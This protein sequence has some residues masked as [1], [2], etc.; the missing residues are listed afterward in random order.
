M[1]KKQ[2]LAEFKENGVTVTRELVRSGTYTGDA[3]RWA[4]AWLARKQVPWLG[5]TIGA[6]GVIVGIVGWFYPH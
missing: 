5:L 4:E 3:R 2:Y 1:T 6:T